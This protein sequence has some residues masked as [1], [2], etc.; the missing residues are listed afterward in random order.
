MFG[1]SNSSVE[2]EMLDRAEPGRS[3]RAMLQMIDVESSPP[4]SAR[5]PGRRF[6]DV[7]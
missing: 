7:C 3:W 1:S 6:A 2:N 4:E 5:Q